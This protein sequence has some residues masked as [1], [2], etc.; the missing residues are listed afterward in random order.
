MPGATPDLGELLAEAVA[1]ARGSIATA[2][3]ATVLEYDPVRQAALVKPAISGRYQDPN[4]G[5]LVPFP[6]PPIA[7]VPV[8]FPSGG[9]CS[10]TWPLVAGD[11][12]YLVIADSSIDEWKATGNQ[13]NLPADV[14]RFD[15]TDAVA[16]PALRP[17]ARS[18]PAT[19]WSSTGIVIEGL[20]IR[21]GSSAA[22]DF[23]ALAGLVAAE[24]AKIRTAFNAHLHTGVT[25][26]PGS[27]GPPATPMVAPGNVAATRVKAV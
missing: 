11:T 4:T 2:I 19:G 9:G 18:I 7:N 24:L 26:G 21:L 8:A 25:T 27:S 23:V 22:S 13:E 1:A 6:L 17:F 12:V 5:A 3:P 15:L 14:R 10:I 16:I 20:D